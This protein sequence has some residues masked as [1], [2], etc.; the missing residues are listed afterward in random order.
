MLKVLL[1]SKIVP[2]CQCIE[3]ELGWR[4]FWQSCW[5][6]SGHFQ[7]TCSR[8]HPA[9]S[10]QSSLAWQ[11]SKAF[12]RY[13]AVAATGM[14]SADGGSL[15]CPGLALAPAL[16]HTHTGWDDLLLL[17]RTL[18][19]ECW[20]FQ[21]SY[22]SRWFKLCQLCLPRGI[23]NWSCAIAA[24]NCRQV[25]LTHLSLLVVMDHKP[26]SMPAARQTHSDTWL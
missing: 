20:L 15:A 26:T 14:Q 12:T 4:L 23:C 10:Q 19:A 16:T 24:L 7:S 17:G 2:L 9:S 6:W 18:Q 25:L 1:W 13:P 22:F 8:H 3:R 21:F 11:I 5:T